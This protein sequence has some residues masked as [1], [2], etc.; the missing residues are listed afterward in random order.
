MSVPALDDAHVGFLA[1]FGVT[2]RKLPVLGAE[3]AGVDLRTMAQD[4]KLVPVLEEIMAEQGFIVFRDQG[5]LSGDEQVQA[6]ELFGG[7]RIDSRHGIHPRAPNE[8]VFRVSNDQEHGIVGIGPLW[9]ND[10]SFLRAVFSHAAF[11]AIVVAEHGGGTCFSHQGA[12]FD[13]LTREEQEVWSRRVSVNSNS[14][15]IHPLVHQH[16][17]SGRKSVWL[18]LGMTGAV[19][20]MRP[21]IGKVK[22]LNDLR[23]L[24]HDELSQLLSRYHDLLSNPAH[25]CEHEYAEGDFLVLDNL[26]VGHRASTNA[27]TPASVQG[28]RILH[29]TTVAGMINFDP[30]DA[31]GV[32]WPDR[33]NAPY[34]LDI[35][36][37]NPFG[38]G[39]F[40]SG[41]LGFQWDP[42]IRMQN[43]T[44][45]EAHHKDYV[46]AFAGIAARE[47]D[48]PRPRTH[49]CVTNRQT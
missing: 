48:Y 21:G 26:A 1:Q 40:V 37:Q 42:A 16:P 38:T 34:Q 18:H 2:V 24:E 11:H 4:S 43:G 19:L 14:G 27:H 36:G 28:L 15:I 39:V 47:Y 44:V 25:C 49:F 13:R 41:G 22:T 20:E 7:K 35:R 5:V 9:H 8:H 29:R 46:P 23:L 32:P 17:V 12:A 31:F 3:V 30:P 33:F 10:G 45:R 6:T